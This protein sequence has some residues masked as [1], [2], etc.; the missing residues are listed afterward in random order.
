MA[1]TNKYKIV[2]HGGSDGFSRMI[3]FLWAS[4][5]NRALPVLQY[6][7]SAVEHYNLPSRVCKNLGMENI[8][9]ACLMLQERGFNRGSQITEK[10]VYN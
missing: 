10:Y 7:Q 5:T 4:T 9:V 1:T 6:F 8:E 3:V 2:I